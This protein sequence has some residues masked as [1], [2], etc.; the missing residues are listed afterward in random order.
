MK[1]VVHFQVLTAADPCCR[2][3]GFC[4]GD[5]QEEEEEE[6]EDDDDNDVDVNAPS[7]DASDGG[8]HWRR[9]Q[10]WVRKQQQFK[11]V[12]TGRDGKIL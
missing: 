1:P 9:V 3:C 5:Q 10:E 4:R 8:E 12:G 2:D 11:Q 7:E 6:E